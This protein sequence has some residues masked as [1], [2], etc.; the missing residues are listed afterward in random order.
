MKD[1]KTEYVSLKSS[2]AIIRFLDLL[3]SLKFKVPRTIKPN[4]PAQG[5]SKQI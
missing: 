4:N 1:E 5:P 3:P 2:I